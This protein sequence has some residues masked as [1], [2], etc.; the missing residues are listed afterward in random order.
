MDYKDLL[1][2]YKKGLVNDEE[3]K[4]IEEELKKYGGKF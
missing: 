4:I 1:D 3:K 2:R